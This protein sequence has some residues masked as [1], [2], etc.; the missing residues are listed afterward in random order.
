[1]IGGGEQ[2]RAAGWQAHGVRRADR[3]DAKRLA[4]RLK[5]RDCGLVKMPTIT[6]M[7][8][9]QATFKKNQDQQFGTNDLLGG[10]TYVPLSLQS[11]SYCGN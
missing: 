6:R 8:A 3:R 11:A 4:Y 10:I 9:A 5:S 1:V 2:Q 7:I